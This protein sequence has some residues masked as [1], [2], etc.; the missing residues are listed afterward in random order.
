MQAP[1][2]CLYDGSITL[3]SPHVCQDVAG[4]YGDCGVGS[5]AFAYFDFFYVLTCFIVRRSPYCAE[6]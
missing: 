4:T 5:G 6:Q 3:F 1:V 2:I